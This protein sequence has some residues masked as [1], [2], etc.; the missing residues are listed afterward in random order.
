MTEI[1]LV[2]PG[3][4]GRT[5]VELLPREKFR[6]GPVL[7]RSATSSRRAVRELEAGFVAEDAEAFASSKIILFSVTDDALPLVVKQFSATSF[8]LE[9]KVVLHTSGVCASAV[10]Q[11]LQTRGAAVGSM[12]PL[13]IF[14]RPV[15][16]LA[17]VHFTVEGDR[18]AVVTARRLIRAWGGKFQ[19]VKPEQR[20]H[21]SIA[22]SLSS[23]M[24]TGLVEI[25]VQQMVAGGF[26]RRRGLSALSRVLQAA[27]EDYAR[28]GRSSRPGPLLSGD[29]STVHAQ[30][31]ALEEADPELAQAYRMAS[32]QTLRTLQKE[33]VESILPADPAAGREV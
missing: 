2:G 15:P 32:R 12:H 5:L 20:I 1:G 22:R 30:L 4:V 28:S 25:A 26:S 29:L 3:R 23:D 11:P 8:S 16:S 24:L 33:T 17:D 6:L 31:K 18:Q 14:Q 13:Y 10:L 19:L 7:S 21:H 9:H 27:Q